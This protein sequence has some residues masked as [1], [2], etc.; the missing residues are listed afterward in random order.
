MRR[1][2]ALALALLLFAA[3]DP[4]TALAQGLSPLV[5]STDLLVQGRHWNGRTVRYQGQVVGSP[6]R[7]GRWDWITVSDGENAIGILLPSAMLTQIH[8]FGSYWRTGDVV[9]VRGVFWRTDPVQGGE[10]DIVASS[11][12][13]IGRGHTV[14]H[15]VPRILWVLAGVFVVCALSLGYVL[16]RRERRPS[17]R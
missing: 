2:S 10:T 15:P 3:L 11:L 8:S 5:T 17:D 6:F 1:L 14:P 12:Q 13:A 16:L 7:R 4:G 9:R